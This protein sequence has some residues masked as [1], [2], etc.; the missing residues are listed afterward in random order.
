MARFIT[1]LVSQEILVPTM[2][3]LSEYLPYTDDH[4]MAITA[5]PSP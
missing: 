5:F 4:T 1:E 3:E 2:L